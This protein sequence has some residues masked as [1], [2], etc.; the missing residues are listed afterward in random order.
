MSLV[1]KKQLQRVRDTSS[2]IDG[3]VEM[4]A[5]IR[6]RATADFVQRSEAFFVDLGSEVHVVCVVCMCV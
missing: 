3:S 1:P 6:S 4:A 5:A 2:A